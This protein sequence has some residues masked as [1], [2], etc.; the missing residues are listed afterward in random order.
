[1][2]RNAFPEHP[3]NQP[4]PSEAIPK[5]PV[6]FCTQKSTKEVNMFFSLIAIAAATIAFM[7]G[8]IWIF[9]AAVSYLIATMFPV[10]SVLAVIIGIGLLA[11][12]YYWRQ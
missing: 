6:D 2:K 4:Q 12:K 8:S 3:I 7:G 10:F 11:L 9:S 1:M 5:S